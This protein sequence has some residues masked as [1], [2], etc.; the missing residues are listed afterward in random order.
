M[1]LLEHRMLAQVL[2]EL[3]AKKANFGL[4]QPKLALAP[5]GEMLLTHYPVA[6]DTKGGGLQTIPSTI[7]APRFDRNGIAL[8]DPAA[9][10][11][12]IELEN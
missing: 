4:T 6:Q 3:V 9:V 7:K 5:R 12:Q 10:L 1:I 8:A 2:A 11:T